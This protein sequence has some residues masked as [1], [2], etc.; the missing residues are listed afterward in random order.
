M[1]EWIRLLAEDG[2]GLDEIRPSYEELL[3]ILEWLESNQA[4]DSWRVVLDPD[5][6]TPEQMSKIAS[7]IEVD[8]EEE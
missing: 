5:K 1:N 6:W 3:E 8:E 7:M 4:T 2:E